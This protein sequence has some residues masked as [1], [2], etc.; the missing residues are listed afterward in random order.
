MNSSP[1]SYYDS[2]YNMNV[3][4][5]GH[6]DHYNVNDLEKQLPEYRWYPYNDSIIIPISQDAE[7]AALQDSAQPEDEPDIENAIVRPTEN[8]YANND[9]YNSLISYY[10]NICNNAY[11]LLDFD[12][13]D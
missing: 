9:Y 7:D 12:F 6:F 10:M 3:S 1:Y 5:F 11:T 4:S 13:R 8:R 2:Y